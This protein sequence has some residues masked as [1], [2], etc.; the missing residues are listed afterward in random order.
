MC[1]VPISNLSNLK[2][3]IFFVIKLKV[4]VKAAQLKLISQ[5]QLKALTIKA[6]FSK[7]KPKRKC[8]INTKVDIFY[9]SKHLSL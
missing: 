9:V 3:Q 2:Q 1:T 6:F 5:F 4:K 7:L 8:S